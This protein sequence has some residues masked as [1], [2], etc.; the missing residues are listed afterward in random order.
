[1]RKMTS[2]KFGEKNENLSGYFDLKIKKRGNA[3]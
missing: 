2:S 1:M 3:I